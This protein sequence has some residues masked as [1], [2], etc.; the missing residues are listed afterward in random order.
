MLVEEEDLA[1]ASLDGRERGV[2]SRPAVFKVTVP[3]MGTALRQVSARANQ[4]GMDPLAML[5]SAQAT[6]PVTLARD[7]L[8]VGGVTENKDA[9]LEAVTVQRAAGVS[10]GSTITATP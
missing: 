4:D 2:P 3:E 6:S 10:P 7:T 1:N 9:Q 5:I 8:V